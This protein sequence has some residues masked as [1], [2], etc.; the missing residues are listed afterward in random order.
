MLSRGSV[1]PD[2]SLWKRNGDC[3][4]CWRAWYSLGGCSRTRSAAPPTRS[5][6]SSP[7]HWVS[8]TLPAILAVAMRLEDGSVEL[9]DGLSYRVAD[10]KSCPMANE[11]FGRLS[12]DSLSATGAVLDP[13]VAIGVDFLGGLAA[14]PDANVLYAV[15][16]NSFSNSIPYQVNPPAF[17]SV[18]IAALWIVVAVYNNVRLVH[19]EFACAQR[20][21]AARIELACVLF[22]WRAY[23]R[24][25]AHLGRHSIDCSVDAAA[26]AVVASPVRGNVSPRD[27][28]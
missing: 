16:S 23:L 6:A 20:R 18:S 24:D 4:G 14:K 21:P 13:A 11:S 19:A 7:T 28:Q 5:A 26:F 17:K 27:I 15:A 3:R 25:A 8:F 12:W 1:F 9:S 2:P 10:G 22:V